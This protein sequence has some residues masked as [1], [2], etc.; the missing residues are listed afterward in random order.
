M[1]DVDFDVDFDFDFDFDFDC[2]VMV[3]IIVIGC[4]DDLEDGGEGYVEGGRMG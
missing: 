3:G 1:V 2:L 4:D